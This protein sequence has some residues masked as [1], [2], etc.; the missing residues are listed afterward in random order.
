MYVHRVTTGT[1]KSGV[2][3]LEGSALRDG[4]RRLRASLWG[5]V[6][7][8]VAVSLS[9]EVGIPT[10]PAAHPAASAGTGSSAL[11]AP[12]QAAASA[13]LVRAA[14]SLPGK[15]AATHQ[16][17]AAD[18][19]A[20]LG[21]GGQNLTGRHG[22]PVTQAR[23]VI[24]YLG[25]TEA[26]AAQEAGVL[27][28]S[29]PSARGGRAAQAGQPGRTGGKAGGSGV[30][31]AKRT[32]QVRLTGPRIAP[33]RTL[34]PADLLVVAARTLP[35]T[36]LAA[37][38]RLPGVTAAEALDAA[39]LKING[40]DVA[41]LGVSPAAFR[42][43]AAKPTAT[44]TALWQNVADGAIAVSYLMGKQEKL[45]LGGTIKVTGGR[46]EK[47]VVGGYGTVGISG[48]DAVVSD[49]V[50]RSLGMPAGNAIVISAPDARLTTLINQVEQV[51]PKGA[52]V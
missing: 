14:A 32:R 43:F 16:V 9:P 10:G 36:S 48:V 8:G 39:R 24:Q 26:S 4:Y 11:A 45:P 3:A 34:R 41:V 1:S 22:N 38:R 51:L 47:L 15:P 52:S 29:G 44:A 37:I 25:Q 19:A 6:A 30:P 33:L 20:V 49:S 7:V 12:E 13:A 35:V 5:A 2:C 17:T 18:I 27:L 23:T 31:V 40:G 28:P 50:A 46:T 21:P 42:E